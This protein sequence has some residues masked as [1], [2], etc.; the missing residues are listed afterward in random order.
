M[1]CLRDDFILLR[2][3]AVQRRR[4]QT[5]ALSEDLPQL[6]FSASS[7]RKGR[8]A[9]DADDL[10]DDLDDDEDFNEDDAV[11]LLRNGDAHDLELGQSGQE[12]AVPSYVGRCEA[13]QY[14]MSRLEAKIQQLDALH[15]QHMTRPTFDDES[16]EEVEIRA[17]TKDITDTFNACHQQVKAIRRNTLATCQGIEATI[18]QNMTTYLVNRLQDCT[19]SFSQSQNEY[20]KQ[21]KSREEKSGLIDF[22]DDY[23]NN[24]ASG[25]AILSETNNQM[26]WSKND[27]FWLE[28]NTQFVR[29]REKEIQ[30]VVKSISDLNVI[31]K[32]LASMVS[33]QGQVIDRIDHNIEQT[34]IKVESG[35]KQLKKA[36]QYQRKNRKMKCIVIEAV[37]VVILLLI[38]IITKT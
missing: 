4:F 34:Q 23:G 17:I 14:Q 30:S 13:L 20:L 1:K 11:M 24:D 32:E 3:N 27:V 26:M 18:T 35:L 2:T 10:D 37:I 8:G 15:K 33:E 31:F 7:R 38:L 29:Q 9:A 16:K 12:K 22:D 25:S 5:S 28:E 36:D 21:M 6:R 19:Q